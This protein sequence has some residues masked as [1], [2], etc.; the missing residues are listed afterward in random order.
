MAASPSAAVAA[1]AMGRSAPAPSAA[2]NLNALAVPDAAALPLPGALQIASRGGSNLNGIA[3]STSTAL[4]AARSAETAGEPASSARFPGSL[5]PVRSTAVPSLL[6][7]VWPAAAVPRGQLGALLA[8]SPPAMAFPATTMH[9]APNATPSSA[10]SPLLPHAPAST[11]AHRAVA[12]PAHRVDHTALALPPAQPSPPLASPTAPLASVTRQ[13]HTHSLA[14][15]ATA[16]CSPAPSHPPLH[17]LATPPPPPAPPPSALCRA[18]PAQAILNA[19]GVART[20][21]AGEKGGRGVH[22]ARGGAEPVEGAEEGCEG[23]GVV[24]GGAAHGRAIPSTARRGDEG[25]AMVAHGDGPWHHVQAPGEGKG[26]AGEGKVGEG[27]AQGRGGAGSRQPSAQVLSPR[28]RPRPAL[29]TC[30]AAPHTALYAALPRTTGATPSSRGGTAVGEEAQRAVGRTGDALCVA[31]PQPHAPAPAATAAALAV[32]VRCA[33]AGVVVDGEKRPSGCVGA[34]GAALQCT[35]QA[36]AAGTRASERVWVQQWGQA[37]GHVAPQVLGGGALVKVGSAGGFATRYLS[38]PLH[39]SSAVQGSLAALERYPGGAAAGHGLADPGAAWREG[40]DGGWRV[41]VDRHGGKRKEREGVE[42]EGVGWGERG[43]E[44]ACHEERAGMVERCSAGRE[45]MCAAGGGIAR[46]QHRSMAHAAAAAADHSQEGMEGGGAGGGRGECGGTPGCGTCEVDQGGQGQVREQHEVVRGQGEVAAAEAAEEAAEESILVQLLKKQ[47]LSLAEAIATHDDMRARFLL[48]H[49]WQEVDPVGSPMQRTAFYFVRALSARATAT[50]HLLHTP[51][52]PQVGACRR[53]VRAAGGCVLQVGACRRWVR[54]AGG[55]VPQVGACRRW[56]RA[57]GGCVLQVGAC[58]RWV[59]ARTGRRLSL[60][61]K[62][63]ALGSLSCTH[64]LLC[65]ASLSSRTVLSLF[66]SSTPLPAVSLFLSLC[67]LCGVQEVDNALASVLA[68]APLRHFLSCSATHALHLALMPALTHPHAH[69]HAS[70]AHHAARAAAADSVGTG[71]AVS[72]GQRRVEREGTVKGMALQQEQERQGS[73]TEEGEERPAEQQEAERC[74]EEGRAKTV[75]ED[76][77]GEGTERE[78][79]I[80]RDEGSARGRGGSS[81]CGTEKLGG[82]ATDP[83]VACVRDPASHANEKHTSVHPPSPRALCAPLAV[84]VVD[85][86]QHHAAHCHALLAALTACAPQ[87]RPVSLRLT[88][89]HLLHAHPASPC[90]PPLLPSHHG[91]SADTDSPACA[92]LAAAAP[93][94]P[95]TSCAEHVYALASRAAVPPAAHD[96]EGVAPSLA[97]TDC[98]AVDAAWGPVPGGAAQ[99]MLPARAPPSNPDAAALPGAGDQGADGAAV[100]ASRLPPGTHGLGMAAGHSEAGRLDDCSSAQG[101]HTDTHSLQPSPPLQGSPPTPRST[102]PAAATAAAAPQ[103]CV[104]PAPAYAAPTPALH[105]PSSVHLPHT[106]APSPALSHPTQAASLLVQQVQEVAR[107]LGMHVSVRAVQVGMQGV[108]RE[109]LGVQE[110]EVLLVRAALLLQQLCDASVIRAN[111]RDSLL[112]AIHALRPLL[113]TV[114]E[115]EVG[116][117]S[118]FFLSRFREALEHYS[119]W[120]DCLHAP[121]CPASQAQRGVLEAQVLG[122]GISNIVASEGIHRRM[123]PEHLHA[124]HTRAMR[125]GFD[126]VPIS[127]DVLKPMATAMDTS[128]EGLEVQ[129]RQGAAVLVWKG[130]PLLSTFVLKPSEGATASSTGT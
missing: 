44:G 122:A 65:H 107:G 79:S 93:A 61:H 70:T 41:R 127:G 130:C 81:L 32:P 77:E 54:A 38:H 37:E 20:S 124:W 47:L 85:L 101:Q 27:E 29:H 24:Q 104:L 112:Q 18:G 100:H 17:A 64:C 62:Q 51:S 108:T 106:P 90:T 86:G 36:G 103:C 6:P 58:C 56:V 13:P 57:A 1:E 59:R 53:W 22:A 15:A 42:V 63:L 84:H 121:T 113:V 7:P 129:M 26:E 66:S 83:C 116:L 76:E 46:M 117:N 30:A 33:T 50:A 9:G 110:G 55:C 35:G 31:A 118:P 16:G 49:L 72:E 78:G 8:S 12:P 14:A 75:G 3:C 125:L 97:G 39:G 99:P 80:F 11:A 73:S 71:M 34:G 94:A 105:P 87:H 128:S 95:A 48:Q 89:V 40:A 114:T 98:A 88:L 25:V 23:D 102:A 4:A 91:S 67:M 120:F 19:V 52:M 123:R 126:V 28:A 45:M 43:A 119:A 115:Q 92:G 69:P 60:V 109:A 96:T 10:S 74:W 2:F 68:A 21:A 5:P 82:G 111:P